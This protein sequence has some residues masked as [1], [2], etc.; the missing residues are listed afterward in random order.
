[1]RPKSG[2]PFLAFWAISILLVLAMQ[3]AWA[4]LRLPALFSSHAVLQQGRPIPVWGWA[5]PGDE[6]TVE[7]RGRAVQTTCPDGRW[8]VKLP[9][10]KAGGPDVLVVRG[11][12]ET[13]TLTNVLV[14]EVWVCSGQS[15]MEWPLSRTEGGAAAIAA[16]ANPQLRL[17]TVPKLR[18]ES[19]VDDVKS[20][21]ELC[22]PSTV[23]NFSAVAY[24]FGADLQGARG[25]PVGL[26][27]TSWGGSPAEVWVRE[28]VLAQ[29]PEFKR[30]ILDPYPEARRRFEASLAEWEQEAA[31]LRAEGKQP[32]R[33]RP[34]NSW[35]PA[36][37][38][39]GM[40]YPLIPYAIAGAIWY[41]GESN[42]GRA[43]Q[44][45]R[46]FP[47]MINNWR[48]DWDQGDFPF[49]AVQLA[50]WDKNRQ[51]SFAEIM[52]Q[53]GESDWAELREAQWL[54]TRLLRKVGM[55]VITD[56]GDKDDIHP[57]KK[58]PV[59]ARLALAARSIAYGE[60]MVAS[61]PEFRRLSV[62]RGRAFL[63]FDQVGGG[64]EAR[65]G[66]LK[67]F[68]IC[69]S[70]RRWVWG[71]ARIEGR[72]VVVASPEVPQPVAVRYGWADYP[73]VNLF[74]QE[75][76]PA[77]PFRTDNFPLTTAAKP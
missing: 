33:G 53:P 37:L 71:E 76:L 66:P 8:S 58:Q 21:W 55:A 56:A 24:H 6:V 3:P 59:G 75:G 68:Q 51:R 12:T 32:T 72:R 42:A 27:H 64:L 69:G 23:G 7:F 16:S 45:A 54:T 73:V 30:D 2:K 17:F 43:D 70:D 61:G 35:R 38:Y 44:Y 67:G 1:M 60:R 36:E 10:Q 65:G 57:T 46:L 20:R 74:N 49:L 63:S 26:I 29:S 4:G 28:E 13:I 77:T 41:Q 52:A 31:R 11:R 15:N 39:N 19:P 25:V 47:T 34:W 9:R 62:S 48:S 5:D 22:E 40:I 18:A 14:G 50:P